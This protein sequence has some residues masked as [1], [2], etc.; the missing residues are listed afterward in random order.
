MSVSAF[1]ADIKASCRAL[2]IGPTSHLTSRQSSDFATSTDVF[3]PSRRVGRNEIGCHSLDFGDPYLAPRRYESKVQL[4]HREGN[5]NR[6]DT[7]MKK[8]SEERK[9]YAKIIAQAWVDEEFKKRLLDDPATVLKE[10]GIEIPEGMTVKVVEQK[11]NEIRIPLPP[12]PS[13]LSLSVEELLERT[14]ASGWSCWAG[15]L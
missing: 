7:A 1:L 8:T 9:E 13:N 5:H 3:R 14:Q 10:N 11:E 2:L 6:K 12:K 4:Q 15:C